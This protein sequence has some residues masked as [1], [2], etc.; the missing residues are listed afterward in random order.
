M[1]ESA[2]YLFALRDFDALNVKCNLFL[3]T[4]KGHKNVGIT[5][6]VLCC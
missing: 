2:F 1:G 4:E 3:C 6:Y 5:Q